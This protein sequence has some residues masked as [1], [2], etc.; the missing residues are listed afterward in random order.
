MPENVWIPKELHF[1][2][3]S[4]G[5]RVVGV[6]N[7]N[8][9][10]EE[11]PEFADFLGTEE[12]DWDHPSASV[13]DYT[14]DACGLLRKRW[15]IKIALVIALCVALTLV[16]AVIWTVRAAAVVPEEAW[17]PLNIG[18]RGVESGVVLETKGEASILVL[19]APAPGTNSIIVTPERS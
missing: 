17:M 2:T 9:S 3:N 6:F 18:S 13:V 8:S 12:T 10:K 15:L 1:Y 16:S 7:R 4:G 11:W 19:A 14:V 5:R